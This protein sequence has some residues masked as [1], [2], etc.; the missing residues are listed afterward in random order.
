ASQPEAAESLHEASRV[1]AQ[2]FEIQS[3]PEAVSEESV[4]SESVS[5]IEP[6]IEPEAAPSA[7]STNEIRW[8]AENIPVSAEEASMELDK[9]MQQAQ[10]ASTTL[11]SE[12]S[13]ASVSES[14]QQVPTPVEEQLPPMQ[15]EAPADTAFAAA[16]SA[17]AGVFAVSA[18]PS[19]LTE[20]A[21]EGVRS[22]AAAAWQNWQ[23]I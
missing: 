6:A 21:A 13:E 22:E 20:N 1:S 8:I 7:H 23:Q 2:E 18:E 5:L 9:E 17:S 11:A 12:I 16:A 3:A 14:Q 19:N 15:E 10:A 4:A